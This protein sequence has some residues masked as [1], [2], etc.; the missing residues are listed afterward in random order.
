MLDWDQ[1]GTVDESEIEI[2]TLASGV[3][4]LVAR[5]REMSRDIAGASPQRVCCSG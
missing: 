5:C 2:E 3:W 1:I 4:L